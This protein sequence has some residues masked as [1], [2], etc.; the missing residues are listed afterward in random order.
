M[1]STD[2]LEMMTADTSKLVCSWDQKGSGEWFSG[3]T[4][5][6]KVLHK[7]NKNAWTVVTVQ[8]TGYI[9]SVHN[10]F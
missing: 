6:Q 8:K 4:Q 5:T 7:K 9:K 2:I 1:V 10:K 3:G